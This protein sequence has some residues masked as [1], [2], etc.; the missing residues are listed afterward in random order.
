MRCQ[1]IAYMAGDADLFLFLN[2]AKERQAEQSAAE[3]LRHGQ[4]PLVVAEFLLPSACCAAEYGETRPGYGAPGRLLDQLIAHRPI[5]EQ[6]VEH[7]IAA[8]ALVGNARQTEQ[9]LGLQG[10]NCT[11]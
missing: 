2:L 9:A 6:D 3:V 4:V 10:F 7:G 11:R 8:L 1:I 5:M